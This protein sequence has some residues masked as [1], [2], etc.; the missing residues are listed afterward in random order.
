M[1]RKKKQ[2][3]GY[4]VLFRQGKDG[5]RSRYVLSF[6]PG[7]GGPWP[8]KVMPE[9]ITTDRDADAW[10][11][12]FLATERGAG[13]LARP[14]SPGTEPTLRSVYPKWQAILAG[15]IKRKAT[16][17]S[18]LSPINTWVMKPLPGEAQALGDLPISHLT[19]D[20]LR[21]W[22]RK[23]RDG[24]THRGKP[25]APFSTRNVLTALTHFLDDVRAEPWGVKLGENPARDAAVR[26][27]LPKMRTKHGLKKLVVPIENAQALV[28]C[29]DVPLERRVRYAIAFLSGMSDGEIAALTWADVVTDRAVPHFDV[30]KASQIE[31]DEG[32]G[33]VGET[34]TDNR[35]RLVPMHPAAQAALGAWKSEGWERVY[36]RSG[37]TPGDYVFLGKKGVVYR[38]KSADYLRKD[39]KRAGQPDEIRGFPI[40]FRHARTSFASWLNACGIDDDTVGRIMGHA[41]SSVTSGSYIEGDMKRLAAA[42]L[43][44]SFRW[45]EAPVTVPLTVPAAQSV[46][47]GSSTLGEKQ[48]LLAR[49]A[50]EIRTRDLRFTKSPSGYGQL[51]RIPTADGNCATWPGESNGPIGGNGTLESSGTMPAQR[52]ARVIALPV[53][54]AD[55]G[56]ETPPRAVSSIPDV[57]LIIRRGIER[58]VRRGGGGR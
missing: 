46:P 21:E 14:A 6:D 35:M 53:R 32:Y 18:H 26:V 1:A 7:D 49:A 22:L 23:V 13:R 50:F 27:E 16:R 8:Q 37:P 19:V 48:A 33:T 40:E 58:V 51:C 10:A 55:W 3:R 44:L 5:R 45:A 47:G 31:N 4:S 29:A 28:L 25:M 30:N 9:A 43:S 11:R 56:I 24:N 52:L 38:P 15:R 2:P 42:V 17:K 36:Q 54:R 34:K 39:L 57:G 12:T 20:V 41:G